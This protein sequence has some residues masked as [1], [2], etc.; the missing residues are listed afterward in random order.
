MSKIAYAKQEY[1][2][3][4]FKDLQ[5]MFSSQNINLDHVSF[6]CP[7]YKHTIDDATFHKY[8]KNQKVLTMRKEPMNKGQ[9]SLI[10]NYRETLKEEI[11]KN[12]S[13]GKFFIFES[14]ALISKDIAQLNDFLTSIKDKKVGT[15]YIL[16]C[17]KI[18]LII[19]LL[20]G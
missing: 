4:Q 14:D 5:N 20:I 13:D 2:P 12:Y 6:I 19:L 10:I 7:T 11:E 9:L 8:T 3:D 17:I 16:E 18:F 1:E 15:Q